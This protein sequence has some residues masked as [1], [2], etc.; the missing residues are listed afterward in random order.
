M[1]NEYKRLQNEKIMNIKKEWGN[2]VNNKKVNRKLISNEIYESWQRSK[3][4]QI[5][6]YGK[7]D[8]DLLTGEEISKREKASYELIKAALKYIEMLD[9]II[10]G[11]GLRISLFDADGYCLRLT[12]EEEV[13]QKDDDIGFAVGSNRS[14]KLAGT[15]AVGLCL[16]LNKPIQVLGPEHYNQ[17]HHDVNC[18]AVA[19]HNA[20]KEII[21]AIN[22]SSFAAELKETYKKCMYSFVVFLAQPSAILDGIEIAARLIWLTIPYISSF[23]Y[24]FVSS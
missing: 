17:L 6:P 21:G 20:Y 15:N 18:S 8:I 13:T 3:Q 16:M 11:N 2:F 12:E 7:I 24:D 5:N 14:E 22:I 4:Y 1:E 23:G 19:I 10:T 9:E